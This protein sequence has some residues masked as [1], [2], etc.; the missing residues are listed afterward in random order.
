MFRMYRAASHNNM[1][2]LEAHKSSGRSSMASSSQDGSVDNVN[3]KGDPDMRGYLL[4]WTNYLKG[5]QKR[6][7]VLSKTVLM[8][9]RSPSDVPAHPR[10]S[11]RLKGASVSTEE[12]YSFAIHKPGDQTFHL[13]ASSE[14]ERQ[15]W[16][17]AIELAKTR[18]GKGDDSSEDDDDVDVSSKDD[19]Q[20]VIRNLNLKID[21]LN[22]CY[23]QISK[24]G[25]SLQGLIADLESVN[26]PAEANSKAK[27]VVERATLFRLTS[28][29]LLNASKEFVVMAQAEGKKWQKMLGH[30]HDQRT[31]L[32]EMVEQLAKQHSNLEEAAKAESA[33]VSSFMQQVS[34]SGSTAKGVPTG[35]SDE[36]EFFDAVDQFPE[37]F[38]VSVSVPTPEGQPS[39][40]RTHKRT[41]SSMSLNNENADISNMADSDEETDD[42]MQRQERQISVIT[43]KNAPPVGSSK[44]ALQGINEA[45]F[46]NV[47]AT[48]TTDRKSRGRPRRTAIPFR[49]TASLSLWSIMKN[50]IGRDLSKIPMPVNFSEPL[51]MIQRLTEDFEYSDI[52][53]RAAAVDDHFEQMA[54]VA[55]FTVSSYATTAVRTNKPFNPMLG[56]TFE[57]DRR[58]DF[59][60]RAIGEQ[61]SH[62]PP[63]VAQH[64]ESKD[65][66]CWQEFTAS[67]KFRGKYLQVIP[68][69]ITHLV[70]RKTDNHYTWRKVTTT[71][72]NIIVGKLWIDQSGDMEIKNH[73]TGDVCM[74]KYSSYSY[75]SRD[76]P[77]KVTGAVT[78]S[79]GNVKY[80]L[81]GTWDDSIAVA[82]VLGDNSSKKEVIETDAPTT[83]WKRN[84]LPPNSDKMYNFGKFALEL[85]EPEEG[86]APTDSRNRPD[87]RL[88]E[89]GNWDEA[90]KY[91]QKLEDKQRAAR[92][93]REATAEN[94]NT[95]PD[96]VAASIRKHYTE[97]VWFERRKD[98]LTGSPIW[99]TNGKY[100]DCK[101]K[102]DWSMCPDIF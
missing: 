36:D 43:R 89:Q 60:W 40:I 27:A 84:Q 47:P 10:G 30:E 91:K 32:A 22:A 74:L 58:E 95:P 7:F 90:N 56:E 75:F 3:A 46:R 79:A 77:R 69:G 52:L 35:P 68:L 57:F 2:P 45:D 86:V 99:I 44:R 31:R 50:C 53:D 59:G 34:T 97:P 51:S 67:T 18:A 15:R 4:K 70:F 94:P 85:N 96:E 55:S 81:N 25:R 41:E 92:K 38:V 82:K 62:H 9:F 14:V 16:V 28:S 19:L 42:K 64:V 100:W 83:L 21:E 101:A 88:M 6:Y 5:Y 65:W 20:G 23:E 98:P 24:Q 1:M 76:T 49:P 71:V 61:V 11:I 78:D 93:H 13:K 66:V 39:F 29:A 12:S 17:T 102:Q 63:M 37:E 73:K 87:Q 72:N 48:F 33:K 80:V 26:I 54:Y 8:Y